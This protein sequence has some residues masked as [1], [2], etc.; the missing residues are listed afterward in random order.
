MAIAWNR[1]QKGNDLQRTALATLGLLFLTL[2]SG[3]ALPVA[4]ASSDDAITYKMKPGD[5]L[6]GLAERYMVSPDRYRS[7]QR[8]NRIADP[9]SVPVGQVITIPRDLLKYKA[10]DARFVAVRGNVTAGSAAADVGQ[11]VREGTTISTGPASFATLSL[12][13]GSRVSLPSNSD[14]RIRRSRIYVLGGSVDFDFDILKGGTRSTVTKKKSPDDRFR[15]RTPKAVSAVRG[16]DFQTRIDPLTSR[17]FAE[18]VEGGLAVDTGTGAA[19]LAQGNGL[20]VTDDRQVIKEALLPP[21]NLPG[22]GK[23]QSEKIVRFAAETPTPTRFTIAADSSFIEQLADVI[24]SDGVANIADLP[25]GNYFVRGRTISANGI[26][27]LPATFAFKR[28]LNGVTASV[29]QGDEGYVFRWASEGEGKRNFHFQLFFE[30]T[31]NAPIIDEAGL[32]GDRVSISDLPPGKYQWRVAAV[33]YLDG[34][35][36]INWTPLETLTVS[37]D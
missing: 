13:D 4:A 16:T 15:M 22:A 27:G 30:S 20:A 25:N 34:E 17:D 26:Q 36:G 12:P 14:V 33:Q 3:T 28:R 18:V 23:T 29:G 5:T 19:P 21:P 7:V 11:I 9:H 1:L 8:Q 35:V 6:I 2:I 24:A 10:A 31:K 37:G 32:S